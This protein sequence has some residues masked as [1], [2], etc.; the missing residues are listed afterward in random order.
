MQTN[1][2]A[3][4]GR[5]GRSLPVS[6][7]AAP[8]TSS[9][10]LANLRRLV[11]AR[12]DSALGDVE[13]YA[14]AHA[15]ETATL[16]T[17][18]RALTLR[19]GKRLRSVLIMA[20]VETVAPWQE[21]HHAVIDA[22][23]AI[24]LFQS[25]LL[26]QDDWMDGDEMRRGG[27]TAHIVLGSALGS[28]HRG[29]AG[30]VLLGDLASALAQGLL[31]GLDIPQSRVAAVLRDFVELQREVA[32]G[33]MLDIMNAENHDAVCSLKTGS[34]TVS[35]PLVLGHTLAGGSVAGRRALK[36]YAA[37]LG[38]AF[39]LRDDI[40]GLFGRDEEIGKSSGAD[41]RAAKPTALM[42]EALRRLSGGAREELASLQ[43]R[44]DAEALERAR[45]LVRQS[46]ALET[47]EQRIAELRTTAL[48]SLETSELRPSG[49]ALLQQV[50]QKLTERAN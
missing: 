38:I 48:A 13:S 42:Q 44:P 25:Y 11:D 26:L 1:E 45:S 50:A 23:A 22:A 9:Q 31:A 30:A 36:L 40:L 10:V 17:Q 2:L 32:I 8:E 3:G 16:L 34:Y 35:G 43:G 4:E 37:P 5:P 7:F 27:P 28:V 41:L 46:G 15:P 24:E 29:A 47:I 33:Q 14:D 6:S 18:L 39:Q 20:G 19:G 21:H 49:C 12:L